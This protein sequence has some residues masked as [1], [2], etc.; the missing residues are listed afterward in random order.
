MSDFRTRQ[1]TGDLSE[2]QSGANLKSGTTLQNR[3]LIMGVLGV[4]GMGAVYKARDLHFPGVTKVVAVKEMI[5]PTGDPSMRQMVIRNFEREANLLATLSHPAIPKI[6]DLFAHEEHS[7]LVM[8]LINGKDLEAILNDTPGFLPIEQVIEWAVQLCEVLTYLHS[9]QPAPI[10]FRDMKPSNVMIDHHGHV[11]LIDFGIAKG[12]QV[13]QRG[14]M[15]G[16]EGYSPPEQYRGEA[17]PLGDVYA[18][19][20]TLHHLFTKRDPR[21]EPPFSFS[22]RPIRA[23]N[24][25]ATEALEAIVNKALGYNPPDRFPSVE[26]MKQALTALRGNAPATAEQTKAATQAFLGGTH[27]TPI[28]SF[29]CEDEIRGQPLV[30][31]K[32]VVVGAYDNNL[33]AVGRAD[34]KFVWKFAAAGGFAA[35]PIFEGGHI[36]VGSEDKNLYSISESGRQQW[37]YETAGPIRCTAQ[38]S[39]GHIFIGSDDYHLH[40]V[41]LQTGKRAWRFEAIAPVRSRPAMLAKDGRVLFGCEGGEFYCL[42]YSGTLKWRFRA[43]RGITSSAAVAEGLAIFG[44]ADYHVYA[45]DVTSGWAVWKVRT[46]KPVVS[47]P[48]VTDKTAYIGSAD[49]GLYA[50]DLRSG[51]QLWKFDTDDQIASS[52]AVYDGSVYVGSVDHHVYC[53]DAANGKLRWKFMTEGAVISSPTVVD[54]VVYVGSADHHL[55]ALAA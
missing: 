42:D 10:V 21:L 2:P 50:I 14:T 30:T 6:Y 37:Q 33:Y 22:E 32:Y 17:G 40:V 25:G 51:K 20:A 9:H 48:A 43:K 12:F 15:I 7:Y 45:V 8:E 36:Y 26:A 34:G 4:G 24:P 35:S 41:N 3:Y 16:T 47:S 5:N 46:Q 44:S 39:E 49:G 52:P 54:G 19:G 53:L 29:K 23:I 13:G 55:Y 28:W 11:R 18:L 27:I 1:I 38:I 31:P